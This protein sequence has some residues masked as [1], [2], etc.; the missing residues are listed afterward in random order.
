MGTKKSLGKKKEKS[1]KAKKTPVKKTAKPLSAKAEKTGKKVSGAGKETK[2]KNIS[3]SVTPKKKTSPGEK[4]SSAGKKKV[5]EKK[6]TAKKPEKISIAPGVKAKA[7]KPPKSSE[8]KPVSAKTKKTA[9]KIAPSGETKKTAVKK[10]K[11]VAA[12]KSPKI[13]EKK[14][15]VK[16]A[17]KGKTEV[18]AKAEVKTERKTVPAKTGESWTKTEKKAEAAKKKVSTK[19]IKAPRQI[20]MPEK[21]SLRGKPAVPPVIAEELKK[22]PKPPLK[23][24]LPG[25]ERIEEIVQEVLYHELP[26][27]FG[28]NELFITA[29]DPHYVF[30]SW[31]INKDDISKGEGDLNIRTYDVTGIE[32]D[33]SNSNRILDIRIKNRVGSGFFDIDMHGRD[34]IMEIG[35][36]SSKGRFKPII[37]SNRVSVPRLLSFDELGI[38]QKLYKSGIPVGY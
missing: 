29:V 1:V 17:T 27:E 30:V 21:K 22:P 3:K 24:F 31:E 10:V 33:G 11:K 13:P 7:K 2:P 23:I 37:R 26:E 34:V 25:E 38:V 18:G 14:K 36:L 15:T 6:K 28:E 4:L 16:S 20:A 12:V 19:P 5:A 35:V 8:K 32:F 9:P